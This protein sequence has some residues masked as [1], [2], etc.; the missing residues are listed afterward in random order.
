MGS[1]FFILC[2]LLAGA[3]CS[4]RREEKKPAQSPPTDFWQ[5]HLLYLKPVPH[6]RLHVEVDAVAGCEPSERELEALGRVLREHCDKPEGIE[7]HR[8]NVIPRREARGLSRRELARRWLDG[9][10]EGGKAPAFLYVL[11]YD[12]RLGGARAAA[13]AN[14]HTELLPCPAAV[15]VNRAYKPLWAR[16]VEEELLQHEA[17]HLLGLA[18]RP[19]QAEAGHCTE[20]DCLMRAV[21]PV[22]VKR[23]LT[24]RDPVTNKQFCQHCRAQLRA[25][26]ALP[27]PE[28]LRFVGPVL[29]REERGYRVLSLQG[30]TGLA[31]GGGHDEPALSFMQSERHRKTERG[32]N[33]DGSFFHGWIVDAE[34]KDRVKLRAVLDRACR[35]PYGRVREEAEGLRRQVFP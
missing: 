1:R 21:I 13:R 11:F 3:S 18:F 16:W 9:P 23:L 17:G 32:G 19:S 35:D 31:I 29:V 24:G 34:L 28:N 7:I 14:P 6:G 8:S 27:P 26:A 22:Q 20:K 15:F 10:K 33:P 4:S 2:V 12:G 5:P 25:A 30:A